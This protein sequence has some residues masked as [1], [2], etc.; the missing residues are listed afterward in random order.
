MK[1]HLILKEIAKE[2]K[3]FLP[4]VL[5]LP[6]ILG[7]LWQV[8]ELCKIDPAFIRFFSSTQLLSDGILMLLILGAILTLTISLYF[9]NNITART[10]YD[11][12]AIE[13]CKKNKESFTLFIG[14]VIFFIFALEIFNSIYISFSQNNLSLFIL[15]AKLF[16]AT[17]SLSISLYGFVLSWECFE[18]KIKKYKFISTFFTKM[19]FLLL[20]LINIFIVVILPIIIVLLIHFGLSFP[21]NVINIKNLEKKM[22][23]ENYIS[24][25]LL[26]SNDKYIFIEHTDKNK[27]KSI[28]ILKFDDLFTE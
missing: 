23:N 14:G 20:F 5:L 8:I 17:L 26:Y 4:L 7:G 1:I 19:Y 15:L 2:I 11:K 25:V 21:A 3:D 22:K 13:K 24:N 6:P 18:N 10:N 27:S 28:E 9:L 12:T 16:S